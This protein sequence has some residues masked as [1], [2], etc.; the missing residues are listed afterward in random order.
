MCGVKKT[1]RERRREQRELIL[2]RGEEQLFCLTQDERVL[3]R[4]GKA[5]GTKKENK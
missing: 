5:Q 4:R 3:T 1:E 2:M